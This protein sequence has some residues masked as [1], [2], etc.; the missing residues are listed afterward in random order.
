MRMLVAV[1]VAAALTGC[2][3]GASAPSVPTAPVAPA[4]G[5]G[6]DT[7]GPSL[8]TPRAVHRATALPG[9]AVLFTGGCSAAGCEGVAAAATTARYDPGTGAVSAG[10]RLAVPRLSHTATLLPDGRVLVAG[11][12]PGE[13][14]PPT[15]SVEAVDPATGTITPYGR[16]R[17]ARADHTATLLPGGRVLVAGGR[18]ADGA[19]LRDTE[20][21][22]PDGTVTAG[23]PL[24]GPRTAHTATALGPRIVL[25]GGTGTA[26]PAL[27]TTAVLD[28]RTLRWSAGPR[29]SKPRV[30]HATVALPGGRLLVVGGSP[31]AESA[32]L[33]ADTEVLTGDRFTR[34]PALADGRY[35]LSDAVAV[36]PDGRVLVAGRPTLLAIDVTAGTVRPVPGP[37]LDGRRSFQTLT[38]LPGNRPLIAGG[39]DSGITPTARTWLFP[40]S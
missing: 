31:D 8:G 29:L 16:L 38:L 21:L 36:L 1:A 9:G 37:P 30:K 34:G 27:A 35:K 12:Y 26:D 10:P 19:A 17:T 24:P 33:Y 2:A 11:G 13:G 18:G 15:G 28:V 22:A 20:L 14:A 23:P 32:D 5:G 3:G 4:T 25:V 39:Y 40:P 7:G 6:A